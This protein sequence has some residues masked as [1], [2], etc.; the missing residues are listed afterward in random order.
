MERSEIETSPST[1]S[2]VAHP[3]GGEEG[4]VLEVFNAIGESVA[5]VAV[6]LSAVESLRSDEILT[7]RAFPQAS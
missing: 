5:I 4:C 7:V 2:F 1:A 3:D 6:P